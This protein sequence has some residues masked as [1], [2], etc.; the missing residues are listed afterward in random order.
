MMV[1]IVSLSFTSCSNDDDDDGSLTSMLIGT[2]VYYDDEGYLS[3][4]FESNGTGYIYETTEG[5]DYFRWTFNEEAMRI[6]VRYDND[7]EYSTWKVELLTS[8]KIIIDAPDDFERM[9]FTKK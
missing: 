8:K 2:W 9:A 6:Q 4:T 5:R 1:T 3:V 7:G